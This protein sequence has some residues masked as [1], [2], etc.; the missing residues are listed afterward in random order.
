M[1]VGVVGGGQLARMMAPEFQKLG[2]EAR[3][4]VEES[5]SSADQVYGDVIVG[6]CDDMQKLESLA[7]DLDVLTFEHEHVP[8]E[9]ISALERAKVVVYPCS[10]ALIYAQDKLKMRKKLMQMNIPSPQFSVVNDFSGIIEFA[11][12][13]KSDKVVLKAATGGYDGKG[14]YVFDIRRGAD[15]LPEWVLRGTE[16]LVEE[17]IDFSREL[18]ALVVR[19]NAGELVHYDVVETIQRG[20]VCKTV[21]A[22]APNLK[23]GAVDFQ[24]LAQTMACSIAQELEVVG[25]LAVEMFQRGDELL[26]NELAMRPHNSGHWTIS[27]A[28][29]SQFENHIRAVCGLALGSTARTSKWTV[30]ENIL[31]Q[32]GTNLGNALPSALEIDSRAKVNLYGKS[33]CSGRKL[34]HV[35]ISGED[36]SE[37]LSVSGRISSV[38]EGKK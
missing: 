14:V 26:V 17:C 29:T 38:L 32:E 25:V 5:G 16:L 4:L 6:S 28:V 20:G 27:G 1:L 34:G 21:I 33:A 37:L 30:M 7:S 13:I 35:N 3:V 8:N 19:S 23:Q 22:P 15:E 2:I 24:E 9:Q 10:S 11:E 18:C 31:G 12:N 36:L